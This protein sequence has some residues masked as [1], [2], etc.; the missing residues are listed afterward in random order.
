MNQSHTRNK[1]RAESRV[2]QQ[3]ILGTELKAA[4]LDCAFAQRHKMYVWYDARK[5]KLYCEGWTDR[6]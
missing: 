5:T 4:F 3:G 2:R 1:N 6:W